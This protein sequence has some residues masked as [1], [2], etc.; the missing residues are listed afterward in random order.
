M[1][2]GAFAA[3][4]GPEHPDAGSLAAFAVREINAGR[5][6]LPVEPLYLRRPDAKVPAGY[7]HVTPTA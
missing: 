1:Y 5:A 4:S 6:L 2:P 3:V 7:K